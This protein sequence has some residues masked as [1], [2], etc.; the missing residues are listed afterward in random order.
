MLYDVNVSRI[1]TATLTLRVEASS[2]EEAEEKAI[3]QAHD[4]DFA[5]CVTDYDFESGGVLPVV[6]E[7]TDG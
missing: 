4:T 2:K 7:R 5:G 3:E 1:S 6:T